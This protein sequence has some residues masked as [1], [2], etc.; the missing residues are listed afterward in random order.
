VSSAL[1]RH[2]ARRDRLAARLREGGGQVGLGKETSNLFRDRAGPARRR[3]D[4]REFR[5]V[6][7]V[8]RAAGVLEAEGMASYETLVAACL[9]EGVMPAVVPQL[10]T[11]TLGGAVA[12][13]GIEASSH[14][15]GLVHESVLELEVLTGDGRI[16]VCT[17]HNEHADL[18]YALP[19][20]YGTLG[21]ALRV[22]ARTA[23]VKRYVRLEHR[24][25]RRGED[26]FAALQ[27][28]MRAGEA[29]FVDGTV[30][31]PD[32]MFLTLGRFVEQAPYA[33]DYTYRDIYYRSIGE[34]R[35]DY[36]S[37]HDFIWRWDTDWFWCS[38]NLLAQNPLVRRLY[39]PQRLNSRTYTR[40]MRWNSRVGLTRW[41]DRL[42]GQHG[43]SVIQ[44]VDVPLSRAAEFLDFFAR[45]IGIWP[46]WLCPIAPQAD[47]G[48]FTL[49]PMRREPYVNFGFWDVIHTRKGHEPGHFNRLIEEKVSALGGIKSLYSDSFFG[50][51]E[52]AR[53][54]GGEAYR[55]LK[56]KYDPA[57]TFPELY[58]KC[59]LKH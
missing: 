10:K 8:D 52:F 53:I 15:Y 36:L 18:F 31:A 19:N 56:R 25:F 11:I 27:E 50:R 23:P 6:L 29:D 46:A 33:S 26:C 14:R 17:P 37:A 32:R 16:L 43:E 39:G 47:A 5:D 49:Y 7:R 4:V 51:D 22:V 38:K 24:A 9:A 40:I 28:I 12:G 13:V 3:L 41:L 48:R 57:A 20:S 58:D 2:A 44:D 42:Q 45:E 59:V 55:A 34:K 30:F 1:E 35:E 54:Y 21:Y